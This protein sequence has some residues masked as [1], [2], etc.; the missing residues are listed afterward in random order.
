M[1]LELWHGSPSVRPLLITG[2]PPVT[3]ISAGAE[4]AFKQTLI[5][6]LAGTRVFDPADHAGTCDRRDVGYRKSRVAAFRSSP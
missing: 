2:T 1:G 5:M 4:R 3:L 6:G